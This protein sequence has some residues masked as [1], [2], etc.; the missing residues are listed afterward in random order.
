MPEPDF[1][2]D[3]ALPYAVAMGATALLDGHL[4]RASERGYAPA[5]FVRSDELTPTSFYPYW[6]VLHA[7]LAPSTY[8]ST[9][10]APVSAG[11]ASGGGSF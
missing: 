11:G 2:L 9:G 3:E 10:S 7:S 4:K 8:G 1:D 6:V 5:W